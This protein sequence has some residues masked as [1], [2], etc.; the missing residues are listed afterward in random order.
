MWRRRDTGGVEN[1]PDQVKPPPS[2]E[3]EATRAE[4]IV[5]SLDVEVRVEKG[6]DPDSPLAGLLAAA[7]GRQGPLDEAAYRDFAAQSGGRWASLE[8]L[9]ER[10]GSFEAALA[11]AGISGR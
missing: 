11:A 5:P 2:P 3:F 10:Y 6:S 7:A 9:I 4:R 1:D 8:R